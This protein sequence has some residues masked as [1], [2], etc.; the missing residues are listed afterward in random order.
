MKT[1]VKHLTQMTLIAPCGIDCQLCLAYVRERNACPGCRAEDTNK[2]TSCVTC[3]IKNCEKLTEGGF[4]YCFEC[5]SFP[6]ERVRHLDH[7]YRTKY[8]ASPIENLESIQAVGIRSFL[9]T[10]TKNWTCPQCGAMLCMHK[11]QCLSCGYVWLE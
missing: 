1:M 10:E 5:D 9:R 2:S 6:C 4:K 7:R 3:K 11:P 8:G